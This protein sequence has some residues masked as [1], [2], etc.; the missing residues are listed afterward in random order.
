MTNTIAFR[1]PLQATIYSKFVVPQLTKG[2]WADSAPRNHAQPWKNAE[3]VI[4]EKKLGV[5]FEPAKNNYNLL[6]KE[7]VDSVSE[8]DLKKIKKAAGL[9]EEL[10]K[11]RLRAELLDMMFIMRT[12]RGKPLVTPNRGMIGRPGR[13]TKEMLERLA[14]SKTALKGKTRKKAAA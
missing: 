2:H 3:V 8:Q 1:S 11:R 7:V 9:D 10:T 6:N 5:D 4:D 12:P 13:P 14:Q